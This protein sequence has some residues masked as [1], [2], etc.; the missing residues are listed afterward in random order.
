MKKYKRG[1]GF[2]YWLLLWCV[3]KLGE[4]LGVKFNVYLNNKDA[5]FSDPL[6]QYNKSGLKLE[7]DTETFGYCFKKEKI[8]K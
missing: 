1:I 8:K 3:L 2:F 7:K 4:K 5:T 6:C